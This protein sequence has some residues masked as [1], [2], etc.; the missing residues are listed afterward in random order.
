LAASG[1]EVANFLYPKTI[2][3]E[4]TYWIAR[5]S[6]A[7]G[8]EGEYHYYIIK[9]GAINPTVSEESF[10]SVIPA[11]QAA[12]SAIELLVEWHLH[13]LLYPLPKNRRGRKPKADD[14]AS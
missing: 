4:H 3:Q 5:K 11:N 9:A 10:S 1:V 8:K 12:R 13:L 7:K 6:P 14:S 2:Y